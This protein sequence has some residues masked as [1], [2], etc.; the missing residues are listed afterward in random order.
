MRKAEEKIQISLS[1]YI[2]MQYPK[3]IFTFDASGLKLP[4]GFAVKAKRMRSGRGMP[5]M[6]IFAAKW[7]YHGLFIEIKTKESD[8]YLKD[9]TT[10]KADEHIKEQQAMIER[11]DELGY[12]ATF[13]FG[14]DGC[15]A[16]I[17]WY[18]RGGK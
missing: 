12:F 11:L 1:N 6:M 9:G 13:G 2:R 16:I 18:L 4:M 10:F 3:V 17:D 15:K 5:D 7:S 8:V 14:F